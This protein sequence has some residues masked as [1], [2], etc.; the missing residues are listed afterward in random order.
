LNQSKGRVI[1]ENDIKKSLNEFIERDLMKI[2]K[3]IFKELKEKD[4]TFS[5]ILVGKVKKRKIEITDILESFHRYSISVTK[6][7]L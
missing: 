4:K 7:D 3:C 5:E 2:I 1:G 6:D